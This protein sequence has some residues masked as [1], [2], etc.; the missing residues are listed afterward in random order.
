MERT[1]S[2]ALQQFRGQ[3]SSYRDSKPTDNKDEAW[4]H[5]DGLVKMYIY[6]NVTQSLLNMIL[7]S[8]AT[9]H[10]VWTSQT[11]F[12]DNQQTH[13]IEL[14][15]ELRTLTL[16]DLIISQYCERMK[17][18]SYLLSNIDSLVHEPTLVTYPITGLSPK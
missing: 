5:L 4:V 3:G 6:D 11:L 18:I 2:N 1:F 12:R 9:I 16:G 8:G 13:A 14:D 17:V 10:T 15:Q 7:N